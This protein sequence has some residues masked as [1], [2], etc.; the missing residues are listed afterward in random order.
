MYCVDIETF[1]KFADIQ[2]INLEGTYL[3]GLQDKSII[4]Y[5][6]EGIV[7]AKVEVYSAIELKSIILNKKITNHKNKYWIRGAE[8]KIDSEGA[9]IKEFSLQ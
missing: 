9:P 6:N 3:I 4:E 5:K 1:L 8:W 2:K 7:M